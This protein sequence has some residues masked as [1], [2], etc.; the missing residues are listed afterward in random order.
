MDTKDL[1]AFLQVY[2]CKS[3][4][5]AAQACFMSPQ[6]LSKLIRNLEQ[7]LETT[8]FFRTPQGMEPT[9]SGEYLY[10]NSRMMLNFFEQVRTSIRE[11]CRELYRPLNVASVTG[12]L[13]YLTIDFLVDFQN[14]YPNIPLFVQELSDD[15]VDQRMQSGEAELGFMAGPVDPTKYHAEFFTSHRHCLVIHKD[16]PLAQKPS[17]DYMDLDGEPIALIGR[18]C[19]PF[20]N[21]M[22]RFRRAGTRPVIRLEASEI[23]LTHE[24]ARMNRGH[25]LSVDFPAWYH[26][27]PDT[28]IRPFTDPNC[29][30][31]TYII[32]KKGT[33]LSPEASCFRE[34]AFSW[35]AANR[36]RLFMWPEDLVPLP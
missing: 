4:S 26:P 15:V 25:G 11:G 24:I 30:W 28:V 12:V 34:F 1:N 19:H 27:Y 8:L 22:N 31:D 17:I 33:I 6:G 13:R 14:E 23:D 3:L 36:H 18:D 7:E 20:H 2:Q 10:R 9:R 35:L 29:T 16:H 21:N 5:A 32:H